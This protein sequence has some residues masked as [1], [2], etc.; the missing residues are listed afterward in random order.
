MPE[1]EPHP[2]PGPG[3]LA[4]RPVPAGGYLPQPG[5]PERVTA[6]RIEELLAAGDTG[7]AQHPVYELEHGLGAWKGTSP[8]R[9]LNHLLSLGMVRPRATAAS[10]A[11]A[12]A[13][14]LEGASGPGTSPAAAP[15]PLGGVSPR[16]QDGWTPLVGW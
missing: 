7:G 14:H 11:P 2:N 10:I 12:P 8:W 1:N 4:A 5:I 16:G 6:L 3:L 13:G 9:L 15:V